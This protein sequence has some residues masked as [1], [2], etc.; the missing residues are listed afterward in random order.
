MLHEAI[1]DVGR[2]VAPQR[3]LAGDK[4]EATGQF[5]SHKVSS[6]SD[7]VFARVRDEILHDKFPG[8][9]TGDCD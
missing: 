1:T 8:G 3:F 7:L 2:E 6:L 5:L 4:G 9:D